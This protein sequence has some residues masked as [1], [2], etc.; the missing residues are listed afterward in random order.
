[1]ATI[2][3]AYINAL[4][5]DATYVDGL[6]DGLTGGRLEDKLKIRMTPTLAAYIGKNFEVVTHIESNDVVGSGFDATVFKRLI[7]G[8]VF[9]SM[10]GT[11][12]LQDF[13]TDIDLTVSSGAKAQ[14]A[15]MVNWWLKNIATAG[16][17]Q[18]ALQ[19]VLINGIFIA[20]NPVEGTGIL[21]S[22][23]GVIVNGHSLGGHLATAFAR[24]F[25]G[26]WPV[27]HV[28]TFN[29]AG[30][31]I[32][33]ESLFKSLDLLVGP[34]VSTGSFPGSGTDSTQTNFFGENGIN[35]TTRTFLNGQ[36]GNRTPLFNE[37]DATQIGNHYMY[38]LTDALALGDA[39][40]K[41]DNTLEFSGLNKIFEQGSNKTAESLEDVLDSLRIML[42]GDGI[43]KTVVG[44]VSDSALSRV[45]YHQNLNAL[46]APD[47][48]GNPTGI[49][50]ELAG[51][52]I[53]NSPPASGASSRNAFGDFLSLYYLAPFTLTTLTTGAEDLLIAAQGDIGT[54][55]KADRDL[56]PAERAEG[57]ATF[58]DDY[59]ND[60]AVLLNA[61]VLQNKM[62][63]TSGTVSG[64]SMPVGRNY[65]V[66]YYGGT[67][68]E[69]ETQAPL[70]TIR[71]S[72]T[73]SGGS[74]E[75]FIAFGDDSNNQ[76]DGTG[77]ALGAHLFGGKGD[78]AF[79][80]KVISANTQPSLM[81][82]TV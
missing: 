73:F 13:I 12:G 48:Q 34:G 49:F 63:D 62:D 66:Q 43:T 25:G 55:W 77:N 45:N 78:D 32:F 57:K 8:Q 39:M 67:P 74:K 28:D 42:T 41:L 15:D 69:G 80:F 9:V 70:Q 54:A 17:G 82:A 61:L 47:A 51:K 11:S 20:A 5:A 44:D 59:L 50:A 53:F 60:R 72:N 29:S 56:T 38:K 24:L 10:Q 79:L 33:S 21:S 1:M 22:L 81:T 7:D 3:E 18:N 58:S 31:T 71:A 14:M 4:L 16:Q 65:K 2:H 26:K 75:Q 19:V 40:A 52:L 46:M 23:T 36:I 37:E 27:Q 35:A 30:F 6:I 64:D 68:R 76:I